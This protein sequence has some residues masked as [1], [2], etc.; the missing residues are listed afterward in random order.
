[1]K[2][3]IRLTKPNIEFPE[4]KRFS[5]PNEPLE[6]SEITAEFGNKEPAAWNEPPTDE[7]R[8]TPKVLPE[9]FR[10]PSKELVEKG[11]KEPNR[12]RNT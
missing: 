9:D 6:G 8:Q 4:V 10:N 2:K 1:M 3:G 11:L 5:A 7:G 12:S